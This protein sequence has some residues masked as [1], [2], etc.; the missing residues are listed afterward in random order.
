MNLQCSQNIYNLFMGRKWFGC[1]TMISEV[2]SAG[3]N[4]QYTIHPV[5]AVLR[6]EM[7]AFLL[8]HRNKVL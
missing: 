7:E 3:H 6:G 2:R 5:R 8:L 4:T 1:K